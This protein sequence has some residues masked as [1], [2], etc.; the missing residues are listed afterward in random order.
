[1]DHVLPSCGVAGV[2]WLPY[3]RILGLSNLARVAGLFVRE[4]Q[5]P[6]RPTT[7][8]AACLHE[9]LEPKG[10]G[11]VLEFTARGARAG[12]QDCYLGTARARLRRPQYTR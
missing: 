7:Q 10:I 1:M 5:L 6:K 8:I 11:V 3:V 4:L 12:H 2:G 9:R